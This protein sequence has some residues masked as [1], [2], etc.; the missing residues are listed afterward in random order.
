MS[1]RGQNANKKG[2]HGNIP[3]LTTPWH[4]SHTEI[5]SGELV[6]LPK[7]KGPPWTKRWVGVGQTKGKVTNK[8]KA[9]Q[10]HEGKSAQQWHN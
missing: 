2:N 5:L 1:K 9:E 8:F 10:N 4:L 3:R 7:H 6:Y